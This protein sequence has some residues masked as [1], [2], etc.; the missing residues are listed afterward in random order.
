MV[1]A[2]ME[3]T[4]GRDKVAAVNVVTDTRKTDPLLAKYNASKQ[5]LDDLTSN[6]SACGTAAAAAAVV[7]CLLVLVGVGVGG[8]GVSVGTVLL[9][10]STPQRSKQKP[11]PN[12]LMKLTRAVLCAV[13]CR[14]VL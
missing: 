12:S 1:R 14:A 3:R 10:E 13:S 8:A 11:A 5:K 2:E 4:Y 6:Y 7:C 9:P